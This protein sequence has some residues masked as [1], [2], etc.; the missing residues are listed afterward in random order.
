VHLAIHHDP[1]SGKQLLKLK[2]PLFDEGWQNEV[3]ASAAN[4]ALSVLSSGPTRERVL[5]L[6]RSAMASTSRLIEGLLARAPRGAVACKAGCAHC[7]HVV[8]AVTAPEALTILDYLKRTLAPAALAQLTQRIAEFRQRTRA[9]SSSER[10]SPEYPCVFLEAGRCSIYEVRPLACRGMN[11]LDSA[12]CETRLRDPAVRAE[13]VANGGGHL[14]VEP[15][16][17]FRAVTAGLQLALSE[18]F[19]LDMRPLELSAVM[20][21][22]LARGDRLAPAWLSGQ[23]PFQDAASEAQPEIR[24]GIS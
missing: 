7:C 22:L 8:V 15:I 24:A 12:E 4:T 23:R 20:D 14:F 9:L 1:E 11:S 18:L 5:A 19:H 21:L 10:F 2:S 17:A 3:A 16:H 6:T 13:F